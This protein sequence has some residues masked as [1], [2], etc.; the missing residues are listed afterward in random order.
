MAMLPPRWFSQMTFPV[1]AVDRLHDAAGVRQIDDPVMHDRRGL[2]GAA[3][4][5]GM[6]PDEL[7]VLDVVL[8]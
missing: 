5:H 4:I 8:S 3:F 1:S 6:L 7:Q 2:V